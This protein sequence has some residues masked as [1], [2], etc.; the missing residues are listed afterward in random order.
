MKEA[1]EDTKEEYARASKELEE[2][3]EKKDG[4]QLFNQHPVSAAKRGKVDREPASW[5]WEKQEMERQLKEQKKKLDDVFA[6][7]K[8]HQQK[9]KA[10]GEDIERVR[11]GLT[12]WG[13]DIGYEIKLQVTN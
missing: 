13:S 10:A 5:R 4:Q 1:H 8:R 11:R 2:F 6:E 9:W 3:R 7:M 12:S